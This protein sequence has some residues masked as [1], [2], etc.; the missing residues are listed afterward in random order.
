MCQDFP[1]RLALPDD[2]TRILPGQQRLPDSGN[3]SRVRTCGEAVIGSRLVSVSPREVY[4]KLAVTSA[5]L[6]S[7]HGNVF[8]LSDN[9]ETN[10]GFYAQIRMFR[11]RSLSYISYVKKGI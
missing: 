6:V 5:A 9:A 7:C 3:P 10:N 1:S 11:C 2:K 4:L 8:L